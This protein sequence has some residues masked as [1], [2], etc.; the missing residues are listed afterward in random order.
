MLD[1]GLF[2]RDI[3]SYLF[4]D[5]ESENKWGIVNKVNMG[6]EWP[7]VYIWI[8]AANR[9]LSPEKYFFKFKLDSY[10]N[11]A[12]EIYLWDIENKSNISVTQSPTGKKNV[13]TVF[14]YDSWTLGNSYHIYAPFERHA[15]NTHPGWDTVYPNEYWKKSDSIIKI[16]EYL[17]RLLNSKDYEGIRQA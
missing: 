2:N 7:I 15:F 5:G 10:P 11:L 8:A 3:D 17:Y 4:V 1:L 16:T 12:P 9:P 6:Q 13:A 14:R